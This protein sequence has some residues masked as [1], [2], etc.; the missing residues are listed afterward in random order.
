MADFDTR[1]NA[2]KNMKSILNKNAILE[3]GDNGTYDDTAVSEFYESMSTELKQKHNELTSTSKTG[4]E[5]LLDEGNN[6]IKKVKTTTGLRAKDVI[7]TDTKRYNQAI[8]NSNRKDTDPPIPPPMTT[9]E[10]NEVVD[11]HNINI[12]TILGVKQA[13]KDHMVEQFGTAV[14]NSHVLKPNSNK[15]KSLDDIDLN[16]LKKATQKNAQ[17]SSYDSTSKNVASVLAYNFNWQITAA[18]NV[19]QLTTK[20]AML[21]S[22]GITFPKSFQVLVIL[23]NMETAIKAG[24]W[25]EDLKDGFRTIRNKYDSD[26]QHDDT[27]YQDVLAELFKADKNRTITDAPPPE[28]V[29][30]DAHEAYESFLDD[31]L[32]ESET[33]D[34]EEASVAESAYSA[35]S[36]DSESSADTKAERRATKK[37]EEKKKARKAA[38]KKKKE[39]ARKAAE[40]K[41]KTTREKKINKDCK[42]CTAQRRWG[43]HPETPEK[44]CRFN[45]KA[46]VWR[47]KWTADL[48]GVE[49]KTRDLFTEENGGYPPIE[50]SDASSGSD[51]E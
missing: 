37:K 38:E 48:I 32:D 33:E 4:L 20:A 29:A 28:A 8:A 9:P 11:R 3:K 49:Y 21:E 7:A 46:K 22:N 15:E 44:K 39:K 24:A 1:D 25:A 6:D 42:H 16:T 35:S 5:E 26:H 31:Y 45:P 41:K 17:R 36:D 43:T 10:A 2:Y 12:Q 27:S 50:D 13:Y 23:R 18:Q 47:P 40:K 19:E 51:S 30:E 14:T 34:E